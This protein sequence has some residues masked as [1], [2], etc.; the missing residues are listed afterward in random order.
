MKRKIITFV[1][2]TLMFVSIFSANHFMIEKVSKHQFISTETRISDDSGNDSIRKN[3]K[4]IK[5]FTVFF[6]PYFN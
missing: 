1:M 3:M 6:S 2:L 5:V 4:L